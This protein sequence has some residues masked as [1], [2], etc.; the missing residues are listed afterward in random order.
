MEGYF[1][2]SD[3]ERGPGGR[4]VLPGVPIAIIHS[5]VP[6]LSGKFVCTVMP[7]FELPKEAKQ[8]AS[9]VFQERA[10]EFFKEHEIPEKELKRRALFA[11]L[12]G[13]EGT[14]ASEALQHL[15]QVESRTAA[16]VAAAEEA[17]SG[18][19]KRR[20]TVPVMTHADDTTEYDRAQDGRVRR[21][22]YAKLKEGSW[23]EP[24]PMYH[25]D[26]PAGDKS[27]YRTPWY[28]AGPAGCGKS[29]FTA[30]LIAK[31]A[32]L[33]P[34]RMIYGICKT[35]MKDDKAYADLPI[36]QIPLKMLAE[37]K[38]SAAKSAKTSDKAGDDETNRVK[39]LFGDY[40]CMIVYDDWDTFR[41]KGER[42]LVLSMMQDTLN[43][44]RKMRISVIVTSHRLANYHET[45]AII[46]EAEF[47]TLFPMDTLRKRLEYLCCDCMGMTPESLER[48]RKIGR[49][50]TVHKRAPMYLMSENTLEMIE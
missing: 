3:E 2:I 40:G 41:K 34:D 19:R 33:W 11:A 37:S 26:D 13:E 10:K 30:K 21:F 8:A 42:D 43:V 45:K 25:M 14:G 4:T 6:S 38:S 17:S 27:E 36:K 46:E 44:G 50:F 1:E 15:E 12:A 20:R 48:A 29:Y 39:Q 7:Q 22:R 32:A 9:L 5:T 47:V 18:I 24:L 23:F 35:R 28:I 31:Y 16:D 49:W